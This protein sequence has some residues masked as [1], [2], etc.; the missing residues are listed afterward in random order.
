MVIDCAS[1]VIF[2]RPENHKQGGGLKGLQVGPEAMGSEAV[3]HLAKV[4]RIAS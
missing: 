3:G 1:S 2:V 4:A